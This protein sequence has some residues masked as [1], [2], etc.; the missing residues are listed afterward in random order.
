MDTLPSS[1]DYSEPMGVIPAGTEN[2]N[3][4]CYAV[5]G[6]TFKAGQQIIV[7]LNNVGY[8]DPKSL[9]IRYKMSLVVPAVA[10]GQGIT[11]QSMSIPGCPVFTPILRLDTLFNSN[12]VES[13]NNYNSV[14]TALSNIGMSAADKMGQQSSLGYLSQAWAGGAYDATAPEVKIDY[15]TINENTDGLT[16]VV[17]N[18][19]A[20]ATLAGTAVFDLSA[21]LP[22]LLSNA[23]KLIPLNGTNIRLQFTLGAQTDVCPSSVTPISQSLYQGLD[24][25]GVAVSAG[26]AALGGLPVAG[27]FGEYTISNFEIVY[28]QIQFPPHIERQILAM[29]KL[30][31]KTSS[32]ATGLQTL[33]AGIAGTVNLVYNLRYASIKALFLLMGPTGAGAAGAAVNVTANKLLESIDI[34]SGTGSYNFQCN[35]VYYPQNPLSTTNNK[36]GVLTELRR[37]MIDLYANNK[38]SMCVDATEFAK[39]DALLGAAANLSVQSV[40]K[41]GKFYVGVNTAKMSDKAVFSGISSQNSPITAIVNI[42]TATRYAYSPIL[43][44]Y[45]DAIVEI[46][47]QTKQVNYIF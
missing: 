3:V 19:V 18:G 31:I 21:P 25:E 41:P 39:T 32:Y 42:G 28:N 12:V 8:L 44:L 46:D 30:R 33:A 36:S 40:S 45:Y 34:T 5:N 7:D 24:V 29:P 23:E 14:A 38:N 43:M 16:L 4:T 26:F 2:Y 17:G 10:L 35:G 20:V 1:V 27:Q 9:S 6:S 47:V 15:S 11:G 22:C 37:A 13:V